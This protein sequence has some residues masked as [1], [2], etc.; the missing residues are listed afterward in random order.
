MYIFVRLYHIIFVIITYFTV[1]ISSLTP[2]DGPLAAESDREYN[3]QNFGHS[4]L[5]YLSVFTSEIQCI[6]E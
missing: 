1:K 2:D 5:I 6:V 4:S 3:K